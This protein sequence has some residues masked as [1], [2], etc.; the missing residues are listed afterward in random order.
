[1]QRYGSK[2]VN[3][4]PL[5]QLFR[6]R[7][8]LRNIVPNPPPPRLKHLG[9]VASFSHRYVSGPDQFIPRMK[10]KP[11]D[12]TCGERFRDNILD[13]FTSPIFTWIMVVWILLVVADGAFF[14]FLM[15][16]AHNIKPVAT[17]NWYLNAS[18]QLL[19]WLFTY[20]AITTFPWRFSNIC[21]MCCNRRSAIGLDFYGRTTDDIWFYI[22]P[23]HR[24]IITFISLLNIASQI[25]N[26]VFR[27]IYF[28][29]EEA[30][31]MP[32][33]LY[34]NLFFGL[35]FSF[36]IISGIYQWMQE[37]KLHTI[38]AEK[39][40]PGDLE[41]VSLFFRSLGS[42]QSVTKSELASP[43]LKDIPEYQ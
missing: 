7:S 17:A 21:N 4:P 29:F 9:S 27:S 39:F 20:T 19:N 25:S 40:G 34:V 23:I 24:H 33:L 35:A 3:R 38:N 28:T 37:N 22:P 13:F 42:S 16:G 12:A 6:M 1:M 15:I 10:S 2:K 36:G 41:K 32:G 31:V 14:F 30:A 5:G 18:I 8:S 43:L 11:A 26:Q